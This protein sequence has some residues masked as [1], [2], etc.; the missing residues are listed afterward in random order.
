MELPRQQ[1]AP[2]RW[3][4]N[5]RI[6][7]FTLTVLGLVILGVVILAPSLKLLVEQQQEISALRTSVSSHRAEVDRLKGQ[8]ARWGDPAYVE[9]QARD[10]L[11]FVYPGEYSYLVIDDGRKPTTSDGAP[12]SDK[13]QSTPVDWV[14]SLQAS[15]LTAGLTSAPADRLTAPVG[16]PPR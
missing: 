7:G 12:I 5:I 13:I 2:E 15:I 14:K 6:S 10:R 3:L 9:A 16:G 4:A 11:L 1:T 8:V